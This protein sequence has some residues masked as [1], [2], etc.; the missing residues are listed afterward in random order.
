MLTFVASGPTNS[1]KRTSLRQHVLQ[2]RRPAAL[3]CT[4]FA[5]IAL[6]SAYNKKLSP[7]SSVTENAQLST[8]TSPS[9]AMSLS[10]ISGMKDIDE[11]ILDASIFKDKVVFAM[12]VASACGYTKPGY[13]LLKRLTTKFPAEHFVAVAVPC[14]S[15]G[16]QE[17]GSPEEIKMFALARAD[18]LVI[19]ERSVVNGGNPHPIFALAKSKFPGRIAWNFDGRFVF[20]RNGNPVAKFGNSATPEEIEAAI[21]K[22]V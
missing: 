5:G 8:S 12:N 20:D 7:F 18:R 11:N 15:F 14:N 4:A 19:T 17:N 10:E 13:E 21:E 6:F 3:A 2:C 22:L 1:F 9:L 16:W